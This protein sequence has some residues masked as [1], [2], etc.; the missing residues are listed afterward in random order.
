MNHANTPHELRRLQARANALSQLLDV[1]EQM[2]I[3]Q[4]GRLTQALEHNC[5]QSMAL[6]DVAA[7]TAAA[8]G[9]DFFRSLVRYLAASLSVKYALVGTLLKGNKPRIGTL[10]F[11]AGDALGESFEYELAGSLCHEVMAQGFRCVSQGVKLAYPQFDKFVELG[12][13]AYCGMPLV[14]RDGRVLGILAILHDQPLLDPLACE[15]IL[16][17]FGARASAELER[18][19]AEQ[20][21]RES[22]QRYRLL[23]DSNPHPMWVYDLDTLE[24]L[25]VNEAAVIHY[26]YS[27]DEFSTMTIRDIRLP[28]EVPTLMAHL[29]KHPSGLDLAGTWRHRKKNGAMIDVEI[30]SHTLEFSGRRADLVLALDVTERKQLEAQLYQRMHQLQVLNELNHAS[31]QAVSLDDLYGTVLQ[32]LRTAV[33]PDQ[34]AMLTVD[35]TGS[36]RVRAWHGLSDHGRQM[37]ERHA[38]WPPSLTVPL[39]VL[40]ADVEQTQMAGTLRNLVSSEG[41]RAFVALPLVVNSRLL[42]ACLLGYAAPQVFV[43]SELELAASIVSHMALAIERK[44]ADDTLRHTQKMEAIGTLAGGIAHDFNNVLT[45][46]LGFTELALLDAN[47]DSVQWSN[48]QQV[49]VAGSRAKT[50]VRQILTFSSRHDLV[51]RPVRMAEVLEEAIGLLRAALPSTITIHA[52]MEANT[53]LVLADPSEIYQIVLNLGTNAGHAMLERGGELSIELDEAAVVGEEAPAKLKLAVGSYLRLTMRDTG[54]GIDTAVLDRIFEPYFTTK[55]RGEGSGMGLSIVHAIVTNLSGGIAVESAL[56]QGTTV[57]IFLPICQ[58]KEQPSSVVLSPIP[59]GTE[60]LLVVDD[61]EPVVRMQGDMLRHLGYH[62][63][64]CTRSVDA[65]E[66]FRT[67]P[68]P[69]SCVLADLTMPELTGL[70]FAKELHVL[71]PDLPVV[72]CTGFEHGLTEA[73]A[74]AMGIAAMLMKPVSM[75]ELGSTIRQ[76]LDRRHVDQPTA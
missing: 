62:V 26:G 53:R 63:V 48:L 58:G 52:R 71:R 19:E 60:R 45:A 16:R 67:D 10:A 6:Q 30:T 38:F 32:G 56:G 68:L 35:A 7:G 64:C 76:V 27:R 51:R 29:A 72:I 24:F 46:L 74:R 44:Q 5:Q 21:L 13:D 23:F 33:H 12:I 36:M 50:L 54:H 15:T 18:L 75:R 8:T 61:E 17:I 3:E 14:S 39:P 47:K 69:F 73:Q 49:L 70:A 31:T 55:A 42:G 2:V 66:R 9:K 1:H 20:A 22:E 59:R 65:L 43:S 28:E 41:I 34:I 11:W 4:T 37:V 57:S 25:A 40:V